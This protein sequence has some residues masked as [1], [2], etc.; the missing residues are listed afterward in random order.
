MK[1]IQVVKPGDV[2]LIDRDIPEIREP[3]QLLIRVK[4]A[5]ICGS[6]VHVLHGTNPVAVYPLVPGHEIAAEVVEAGSGVGR[7]KKGD[8]VVLEPITYCGKCYACKK[9]GRTS[10][11]LCR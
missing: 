1:L 5:G 4:A 7:L 11:Y 10:A 6:D 9:G 2:R 3:S 8:R